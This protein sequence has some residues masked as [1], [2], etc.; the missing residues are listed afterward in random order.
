MSLQQ[1]ILAD[2][3]EDPAEEREFISQCYAASQ[4][5]MA[6]LDLV[7]DVSKLEYGAI[8]PKLDK[9][10]CVALFEELTS[11]LKVKAQNRNLKLTFPVAEGVTIDMVGDRLA[12]GNPFLLDYQFL[13]GLTAAGPADLILDRVPFIFVRC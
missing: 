8:A 7:L 12:F 5:F 2:L 3:C 9:F 6:L 10:D 1:L 11:F 4:K 13:L